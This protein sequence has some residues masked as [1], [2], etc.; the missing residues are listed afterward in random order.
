MING[1][2]EKSFRSKDGLRDA[3]TPD[4]KSPR[5]PLHR[6]WSEPPQHKTDNPGFSGISRVRLRK[7]SSREKSTGVK[8]M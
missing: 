4:W 2:V 7:D 6:G 5:R 8:F 3:Q 1:G